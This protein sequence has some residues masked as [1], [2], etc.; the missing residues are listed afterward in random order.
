[1]MRPDVIVAASTSR[2]CSAARDI[3]GVAVGARLRVRL[4]LVKSKFQFAVY[5]LAT[6]GSIS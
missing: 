5:N 4:Q 1:M 3:A 2:R 6:E